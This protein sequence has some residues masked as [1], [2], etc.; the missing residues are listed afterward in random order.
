MHDRTQSTR[1]LPRVSTAARMYWQTQVSRLANCRMSGTGLAF[2][3]RTR[4]R[5]RFVRLTR[6]YA[7]AVSRDGPR[8]A[9]NG[10]RF[11]DLKEG[12]TF[13]KAQFEFDLIRGPGSAPCPGFPTGLHELVL[14][15]AISVTKKLASSRSQRSCPAVIEMPQLF[16]RRSAGDAS[17]QQTAKRP[18]RFVSVDKDIV[19]PPDQLYID[20]KRLPKTQIVPR[21]FQH[22]A[23]RLDLNQNSDTSQQH[24]F[25]S[26]RVA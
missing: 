22:G 14:S 23:W 21:E 8:I 12:A 11:G 26:S 20:S 10:F 4:T 2:L 6:L 24:P 18:R 15:T 7:I 16:T 19:A 5:Q 25:G 9:V 17:T 13:G 1:S 3:C